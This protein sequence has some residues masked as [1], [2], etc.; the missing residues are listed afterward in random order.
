MAQADLRAFYA[1]VRRKL[2]G[3]RPAEWAAEHPGEHLW[4]RYDD[5]EVCGLCSAVNSA[6]QP[7]P[8]R[9]VTRPRLRSSAY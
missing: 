2:D 9:G 8:C 3:K 1:D 6:K 7:E 4:A 5:G